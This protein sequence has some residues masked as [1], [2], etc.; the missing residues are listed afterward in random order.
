MSDIKRLSLSWM[1]SDR[2]A[3]SNTSTLT[4]L[5]DVLLDAGGYDFKHRIM[6]IRRPF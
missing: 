6:F 4:S 3:S 2:S 5:S 1:L